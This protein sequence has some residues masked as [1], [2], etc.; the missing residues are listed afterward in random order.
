MFV[1]MAAPL[2]PG[3]AVEGFGRKRSVM[4]APHRMATALCVAASM[5]LLSTVPTAYG[6]SKAAQF[7][8]D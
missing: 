3:N 8:C 7:Q 1:C 2:L 6:V 4:E 5:V